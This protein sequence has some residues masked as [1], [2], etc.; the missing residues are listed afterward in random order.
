MKSKTKIF[1]SWEEFHKDINLIVK[2]YNNYGPIIK[3]IYAVPRGG[4]IAGTILSHRLGLPL[5]LDKDKITKYT[6]VVDDI[7][8]TGKTLNR[9]LKDKNYFGVTVLW[10]NGSKMQ[11]VICNYSRIKDDKEWIVFP[12][13]NKTL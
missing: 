9:L 2:S 10:L 13:E 6:L 4:L 1:Y 8:D 11:K 12:W 7:Q 5:I 3:N